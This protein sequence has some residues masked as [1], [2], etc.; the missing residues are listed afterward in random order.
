M[1]LMSVYPGAWWYAFSAASYVLAVLALIMSGLFGALMLSRLFVLLAETREQI[2]DLGDLA[3]NTVGRAADTM[4]LVEIRVSQS[5]GQATLAGKAATR[6]ALSFSTA[7]A[8]LYF[9]AR[10]TALLRGQIRS[11]LGRKR[12]GR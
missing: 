2:L 10:M 5:M 8:G 3:A 9:A 7:L 4:D 6:Q 12:W 1:L 11:K